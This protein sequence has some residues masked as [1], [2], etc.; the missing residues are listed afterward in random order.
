VR[1]WKR[2][3][4]EKAHLVFEKTSDTEKLKKELNTLDEGFCI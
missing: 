3:F 1:N 4:L 2:K